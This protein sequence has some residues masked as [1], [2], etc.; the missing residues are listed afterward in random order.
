MVQSRLQH[1]RVGLQ[2]RP[3]REFSRPR[4]DL[5]GRAR[6]AAAPHDLQFPR[7]RLQG[8]AIHRRRARPDRHRDEA[9]DQGHRQRAARQLQRRAVPVDAQYRRHHHGRRPEDERRSTA[10][11][12]PGTP[13]ICSSW[14]RRCSRRTPPTIRPA[15]SARSPIGRR[16]RSS[17]KYLK[18]PGPLVP[19]DP[20]GEDSQ[21]M[22]IRRI[23]RHRIA[24]ATIRF[25]AGVAAGSAAAADAEHG[26]VLFQACA[27]CHSERPDALGP[28]LRAC[29]AA[30]RRRSRIFAIPNADEAGQSDLGRGQSA[31][32][33]SPTRRPR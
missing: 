12:S 24:G 7:Q 19:R 32:P 13:T 17:S 3:P 33:T 29:S 1:R 18:N 23:P 9:D 30:S 5:Q 4:P 20:A 10:I 21:T 16:R 31:A 25:C 2:L 27:A 28:S 22:Q 8:R 11:A 15:R 14:A 26:K 6:P